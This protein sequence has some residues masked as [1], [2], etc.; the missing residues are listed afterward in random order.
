MLV[1]MEKSWYRKLFSRP[2]QPDLE[3][4]PP[5]ADYGDAD[6]QFGMGLKFANGEGA[7]RD[8]AQA[9]GWYHKAADQSHSLA[10]FNLGMMYAN[11][12]GVSR[13]AAQSAMWFGRAAR[14]GDAGAQFN[15]GESC[16]RASLQGERKDAPESRIEAYKWY[17]LAA[18]QGYLDSETAY[19]TLTLNMT[20]EDVAAGNS[21]VAEFK[22]E[23]PKH[24]H[25]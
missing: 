3:A 1:N 13:N 5:A 25:N 16:H 23:N 12:Q 11:G 10:Q 18:A 20:R 15:L 24:P 17:R 9:A 2:Q 21:R 14:Q 19:K 4:T 22:V 6:V 8:Y 7:T